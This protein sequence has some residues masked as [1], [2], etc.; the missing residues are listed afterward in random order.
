[1]RKGSDGYKPGDKSS[2]FGEIEEG[3]KLP[4]VLGP[5]TS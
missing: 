1:M 2:L 4:F 5:K 3:A